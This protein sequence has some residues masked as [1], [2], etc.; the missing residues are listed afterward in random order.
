MKKKFKRSQVRIEWMLEGF[1]FQI[2]KCLQGLFLQHEVLCCR[3]RTC[4]LF[5]LVKSTFFFLN[6][7]IEELIAILRCSYCFADQKNLGVNYPSAFPKN[8]QQRLHWMQANFI[9]RFCAF[10]RLLPSPFTLNVIINK[11]FFN[12]CPRTALFRGVKLFF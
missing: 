4:Q 7:R 1:L 2:F 10:T 8:G 5:R 9:H 3:D 11:P 12:F 6:S